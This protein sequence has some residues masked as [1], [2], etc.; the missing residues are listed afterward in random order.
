MRCGYYTDLGRRVILAGLKLEAL[1]LIPAL[2][3]P[4]S[5]FV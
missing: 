4:R 5:H 1:G 3:E 2:T